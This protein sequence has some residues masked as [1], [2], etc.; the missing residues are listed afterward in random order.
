MRNGRCSDSRRQEVL[1]RNRGTEP[2][3]DTSAFIAPTAVLVGRVSVGPRTRIMY[4][5]VL[6]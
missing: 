1:I 3:V 5:A 2:I 6:D 4:G